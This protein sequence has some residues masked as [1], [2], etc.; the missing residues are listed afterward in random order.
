MNDPANLS[1]YTDLLRFQ[2][3]TTRHEM[4]LKDQ[5][6]A[7]QRA[8]QNIAHALGLE[9]EY[10]L[11]TREVRITRSQTERSGNRQGTYKWPAKLEHL[12]GACWAELSCHDLKACSELRAPATYFGPRHIKLHLINHADTRSRNDSNEGTPT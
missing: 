5:N 1:L 3:D 4:R 11:I 6:N 10:Y 9:Y 8:I 7:T 2:G 12:Q